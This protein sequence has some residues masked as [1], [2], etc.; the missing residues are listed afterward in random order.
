MEQSLRPPIRYERIVRF[1]LHVL[2]S[3]FQKVRAYGWLA[4]RNK[5]PALAAIRKTLGAQ[6]PETDRNIWTPVSCID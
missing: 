2:P 6:P 1:L 5:Q 4:S 3:G